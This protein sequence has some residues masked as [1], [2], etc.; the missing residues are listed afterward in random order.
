[1]VGDGRRWRP[2]RTVVAIA[3]AVVV[4]L[5]G[6]GWAAVQPL[7]LANDGRL[8]PG[9][10]IDGVDVGGLD[11]SE[12]EAAVVAARN[13]EL[14]ETVRL[15]WP[16]GSLVVSLRELG[17]TID[18]RPAVATAMAR[19]AALPWTELAQIRWGNPDPARELSARLRHDG[20]AVESWL[21]SVAAR[22]V[23]R[24]PTAARLDWSE[25]RP[26]A[27]RGARS[28]QQL[29][30]E[31]GG[32][33]VLAALEAGTGHARLPV[34]RLAPTGAGPGQVLYVDQGAFRLTLYDEGR[35]VKSWPVAIG[36]P[37]YPTPVG[38]YEVTQKRY[39]PTW[40]NPAPDGWGR[41]MPLV[42]GPG[43]RNPL[44][45]R[46]LNW[47]APGAIRFHG[48]AD[49]GSIGRRASKGCVRLANADVIE[50][51]ELVEVG[52]RIISVR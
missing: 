27:L 9:T 10:R 46:A 1:M 15:R 29:D 36:A 19:K 32:E 31:A 26:L 18:A 52:A 8:L 4:A 14:D 17:T 23:V 5:G 22:E 49:L 12:A 28:G 40:V 38:D 33:A 47:S 2:S 21:R 39:L 34:R 20:E 24:R 30:A 16:G 44:G 42:I 50:L 37:R 6:L 13:A 41:N 51:Y 25:G 48:T 35:F 11:P 7:R 45:L 43:A 3:L